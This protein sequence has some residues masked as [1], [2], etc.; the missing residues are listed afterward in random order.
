VSIII[1]D[2]HGCFRTMQALLKKLPD[3][4]IYFV[5]DLVD[6]GPRSNKVIEFLMKHPEMQSVKGNHEEWMYNTI[7]SPR[8]SEVVSWTHP[9]NGG[10]ATLKSYGW[11]PSE[12]FVKYVDEKHLEF[13]NNLPEHIEDGDLFIS[14][15]SYCGFDWGN[16][17]DLTDRDKGR[18]LLW[19]RGEPRKLSKHGKEYFHVFG[20]TP[21]PKPI[22]TD[23][24]ANIDTGACYPQFKEDGFGHL[25][26]LHYPSMKIWTQKYVD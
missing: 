8:F 10:A 13:I 4:K 25:T 2:V 11:K 7:E 6:R 18:S 26:A 23:F 20:H 3:D 21:T 24:Y 1:G 5:G 14:H 12:S 16:A 17:E 9:R 15:S 19:H 22:I